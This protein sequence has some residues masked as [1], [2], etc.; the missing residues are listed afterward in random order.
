MTP[1][2]LLRDSVAEK[3]GY[4]AQHDPA[5][6]VLD[7]NESPYNLPRTLRKKVSG[8]IEDLDYNRYPDP[9]STVLRERMAEYLGVEEERLVAGNGSDELIGYLMLA[10]VNPG[11]RVLAPVPSFSMYRILGDQYH[12]EVETVPLGPD[13]ALTDEFVDASR[14]AKLTFVGS[15]NNPTGNCVKPQRLEDLLEAT[16]GL[17]VLD[18]AYAEFAGKSFL[19]EITDEGNLV[20]LRTLSKAFGLASARVGFLHGPRAIVDGVNTVRLPYNLNNLSQRTAEVILENRESLQGYWDEID[21]ERERLYDFL[22]DE[23]YN[24]C[25]TEANFVLFEPEN[26]DGLYD[27]LLSDGIRIRQ[28]SED[29]VSD[30]LRVTVG[31]PEENDA[32]MKSLRTYRQG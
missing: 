1:E 15:P 18:E 12:A 26:P 10:C 6:I 20:V 27:H 28:F 16:Q 31:R 24:P 23:G 7:A 14:E 9:G 11:D 25:P 19:G 8:R 3:G 5:E 22:E 13:W 29:I 32:V 21:S 30:Y 4:S 2:E 17:V